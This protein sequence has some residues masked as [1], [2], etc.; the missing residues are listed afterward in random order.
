[1]LLAGSRRSEQPKNVHF[2][3]IIRGLKTL[4]GKC[5][6]FF[7]LLGTLSCTRV[8]YGTNAAESHCFALLF[9]SLMIEWRK[10]TDDHIPNRHFLLKTQLSQVKEPEFFLQA[11]VQPL[12]CILTVFTIFCGQKSHPA[13]CAGNSL[14]KKTR[15]LYQPQS[16]ACFVCQHRSCVKSSDNRERDVRKSQ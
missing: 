10:Y 5:H 12:F 14:Q 15:Q 4:N 1:M 13:A 11:D 2:E 8:R 16:R 3:P 6:Y 7:H 9:L